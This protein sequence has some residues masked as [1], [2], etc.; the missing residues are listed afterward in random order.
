MVCFLPSSIT[1]LIWN[2]LIPTDSPSFYIDLSN[3]SIEIKYFIDLAFPYDL[4][5]T[6]LVNDGP[7]HAIVVSSVW[8]IT[9]SIAYGPNVS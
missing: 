2:I 8:S 7:A 9:N 5:S 6:I 1:S 3:S 4:S